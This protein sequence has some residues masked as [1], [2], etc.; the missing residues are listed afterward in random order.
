MTKQV[1]DKEAFSC[2]HYTQDPTHVCFFSLAT[3]QWLA[4]LWQGELQAIGSDVIIF[5][6][7]DK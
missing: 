7:Q 2:W 3:F 6:K 1:I 5:R 4:A